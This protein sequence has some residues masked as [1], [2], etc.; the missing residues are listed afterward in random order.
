M[1]NLPQYN[2][3]RDHKSINKSVLNR[4][5][6]TISSKTMNEDT[7]LPSSMLF[8]GVPEF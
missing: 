3:G 2:K 6:E 8:N 1:R 4:K 5:N 7:C